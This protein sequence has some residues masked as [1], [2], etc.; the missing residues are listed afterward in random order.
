LHSK[1]TES[2][3]VQLFSKLLQLNCQKSYSV[4]CDIGQMTC[5]RG[6]VVALLQE[7]Y[8]N[9]GCVRGLPAGMRVFPDSRANSAVV[10]NDVGTECTLV[11]ST[12]MGAFVLFKW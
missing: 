1:S 9:N 11:N 6:S 8:A 10:L 4:M 12:N 7:P 2:P 3:T 5:E